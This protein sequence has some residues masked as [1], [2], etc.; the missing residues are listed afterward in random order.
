MRQRFP[1]GHLGK[2]QFCHRCAQESGQKREQQSRAHTTTQQRRADD[3]ALRAVVPVATDGIPRPIVVHLA[4]AIQRL[5]SGAS[6]TDLLGKRL[7]HLGTREIVSVPLGRRYRLLLRQRGSERQ[8]LEV[9][10]HEAY[11]HRITS[12]RFGK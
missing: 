11:N 5:D 4:R 12:G 3:R 6:Y 7:M 8:Y 1:C 2:G 10:S 9:L